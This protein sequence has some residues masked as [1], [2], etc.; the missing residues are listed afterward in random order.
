MAS[1]DELFDDYV[2]EDKQTSEMHAGA[3]QNEWGVKLNNDFAGDVS[4]FNKPF[5][6]IELGEGQFMSVEEHGRLVSQH[7]SRQRAGSAANA[8]LDADL[9]WAD[10]SIKKERL[11]GKQLTKGIYAAKNVQLANELAYQVGRIPLHGEQRYLQ[12]RQLSNN[13][14]QLRN[15]VKADA[16]TIALEGSADGDAIDFN[17]IDVEEVD[18]VVEK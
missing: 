7:N 10:V 4:A 18:E 13:V 16:H 1:T 14:Q 6:L 17:T 12:L 3:Y 9:Q 8:K 5:T 15:Q 11:T 2:V